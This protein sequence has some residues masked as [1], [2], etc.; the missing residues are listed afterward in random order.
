MAILVG[1]CGNQIG[2][3]FW[4]LVLYEHGICA[5]NVKPSLKKMRCEALHSFFKVEE[6]K[7][8]VGIDLMKCKIKARVF[9]LY[10]IILSLGLLRIIFIS[11]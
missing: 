3:A 10:Y 1:Q 4:P 5:E 2:H 6:N 9:K 8:S 7:C 11:A